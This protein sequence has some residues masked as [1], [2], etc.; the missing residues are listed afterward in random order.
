MTPRPPWS[1]G[2]PGPLGPQGPQGTPGP[3]PQPQAARRTPKST[4]ARQSGRGRSD[5]SRS[6]YGFRIPIPGSSLDLRSCARLS[7]ACGLRVCA[8]GY[9]CT[10]CG[11]RASGVAPAMLQ[12]CRGTTPGRSGASGRLQDPGPAQVPRAVLGLQS[13]TGPTPVASRPRTQTRRGEWGEQQRRGGKGSNG[14]R[15]R[16]LT[17]LAPLGRCLP[18]AFPSCLLQDAAGI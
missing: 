16:P 6:A 9:A 4:A 5:L 1:P 7:H 12:P 15:G 14:A 18:P 17:L 10:D 11:S 13:P 2:S 8:A 3:S